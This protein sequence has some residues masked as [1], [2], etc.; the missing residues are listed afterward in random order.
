[1][2]LGM[3]SWKDE[4]LCRHAL[5]S[6]DLNYPRRFFYVCVCVSRAYLFLYFMFSIDLSG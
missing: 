2:T 6:L 3:A 1:M 5:K 4:G